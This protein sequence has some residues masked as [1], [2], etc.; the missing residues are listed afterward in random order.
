M[1]G[2]C[3][4]SGFIN[5]KRPVIQYRSRVLSLGL[6]IS[7]ASFADQIFGIIL[8]VVNILN[9]ESTVRV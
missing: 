8:N 5:V 4:R 9:N 7:N 6:C 3:N 2:E 1:D